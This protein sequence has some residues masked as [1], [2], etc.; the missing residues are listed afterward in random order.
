MRS[1]KKIVVGVD[2]SEED[3]LVSMNAPAPQGR[4]ALEKA[5]WLAENLGASLHLLASLD[6][7]AHAEEM[8]RRDQCRGGGVCALAE[9]RLEQLAA[10]ARAKGVEVTTELAFGSPTSVIMDDIAANG[11][12][13]AVVGTRRRGVV[14]RN[15]LG[16]TALGLLRHA[17]IAVWVARKG[18]DDEFDHVLAPVGFGKLTDEVLE[19]ATWV[20]EKLGSHV[21][22][23]HVVDYSGEHVLR[24][25]GADA[26]VL[27]DYRRERRDAVEQRLDELTASSGLGA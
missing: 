12:Q 9:E 17:P 7:H 24:M 8:M 25:G 3:R 15:L 19:S 5:I 6:V 21:H 20:G 26:E 10:P 23:L 11:R 1:C 22:A 2:L 18:P 4:I 16:S 14:A 27:E 13:L